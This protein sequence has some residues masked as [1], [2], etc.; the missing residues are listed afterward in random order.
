M[1]IYRMAT[2]EQ[3]LCRPATTERAVPPTSDNVLF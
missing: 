2:W 3:I 1:R